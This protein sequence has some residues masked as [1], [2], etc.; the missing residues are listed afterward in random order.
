MI[1]AG[2]WRSTGWIFRCMMCT[3]MTDVLEMNVAEH[4]ML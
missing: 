4:E 2:S 3:L 1:D